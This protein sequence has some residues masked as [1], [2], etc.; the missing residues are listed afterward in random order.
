MDFNPSPHT[1]DIFPDHTQT[2]TH[3]H[4]PIHTHNMKT[5]VLV[6]LT[7][8]TK[9]SATCFAS[10]SGKTCA[11]HGLCQNTGECSCFLDGLDLIVQKIMSIR[12]ILDECRFHCRGYGSRLS[13]MLRRRNLR[14]FY[15][16]MRMSNRIQRPRM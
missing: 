14:S 4:T 10:A 16:K 15:R 12:S 2:H 9:S 3:I 13:G 8:I 1:N 5:L 7:L 11:G 6:L